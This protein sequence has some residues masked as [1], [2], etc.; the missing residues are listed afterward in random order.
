MGCL[1]VCLGR[2]KEA[3]EKPLTL[4]LTSC[5]EALEIDERYVIDFA[6]WGLLFRHADNYEQISQSERQSAC[7]LLAG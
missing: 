2:E 7:L 5:F 1:S 3:L 4:P 6:S